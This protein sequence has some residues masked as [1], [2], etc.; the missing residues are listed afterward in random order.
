MR[1]G[2]LANGHHKAMIEFVVGVPGRGTRGVTQ[3]QGARASSP[4]AIEVE[5]M[6]AR[7]A[8]IGS[9]VNPPKGI[10]LKGDTMIHAW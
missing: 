4:D 8:F 9:E 5:R 2:D 7:E 1:F 3:T 10:F 6:K